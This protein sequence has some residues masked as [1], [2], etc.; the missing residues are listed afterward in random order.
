MAD[1]VLNE[2]T[3]SNLFDLTGV[4]AVV[5]GGGTVSHSDRS[6]LCSLVH[7][8][9]GDRLDDHNHAHRQWRYRVYHR[10]KTGRSGQVRTFSVMSSVA[11]RTSDFYALAG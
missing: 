9:I 4:V 10:S 2:L 5:T 3:S 8:T 6:S 1:G 7:T 11:Y